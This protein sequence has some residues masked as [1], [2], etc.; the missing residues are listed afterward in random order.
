MV[1]LVIL[2]ISA[3]V[4]VLVF[5]GVVPWLGNSK[6]KFGG[7]VVAWGT[8][9]K[10]SADAFILSFNK[11]HANEF[12]F[13]YVEKDRESFDKE[14]TEAL[15]S[16]V[17]P[18]L[19]ILPQDLIVRYQNK[20]F[21]IPF[22]SYPLR[23][24]KDNFVEEGE[25][26][27]TPDG[28]LGLPLYVDPIIMYWNRDIF[29]SLGIARPPLYWDELLTLAPEIS[30]TDSVGNINRSAV[31]FGEFSNINNAKDVLS[32]LI[33][34]TGSKI[35]DFVEDRGFVSALSGSGPESALRFFTQFSD[36][37]KR[38]YSWN[39]SLPT[40]KDYF[41]SGKL[42]V[43]FGPAS[44]LS[45]IVAKNPHLNFDLAEVPQV[46]EGGIRATF[47]NISAI[48]VLKASKKIETA[49]VAAFALSGEE[50]AS[51]IAEAIKLAPARRSLLGVDKS[52]PY[53]PVFYKGALISKGWLDPNP[54][55]TERIFQVMVE[56]VTSG[57]DSE[58]GAIRRA[59]LELD[60]LLR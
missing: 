52:D 45:E 29:S 4:A 6:A 35:V 5:A 18:D 14:L 57:R 34:Q 56:G 54:L 53:S 37:V 38:T 58:S 43:Y 15:A 41:A 20:I 36:P 22:D 39:K 13:N 26:Y 28:V 16:G 7:E 30:L 55:E 32:M 47:G 10:R 3:I 12:V 59:H 23:T 2:G 46:R 27:V 33:L 42:A 51:D 17:G 49:F 50:S 60:R 48:S 1:I 9:P 11:K 31:S 21:T 40:S 8:L 25:L 44:E 24:F 19:I